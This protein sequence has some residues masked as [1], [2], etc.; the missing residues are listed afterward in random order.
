MR[1]RIGKRLTAGDRS[2]ARATWEAV[3]AELDRWSARWLDARVATCEAAKPH[4]DQPV[5]LMQLRLACLDEQL[6]SLAAITTLLASEPA[7]LPDADRQLERALAATLELPDPA[8]CDHVSLLGGDLLHD[9]TGDDEDVQ[10]GREQLNHARALLSMAKPDEALAIVDAVLADADAGNLGDDGRGTLRAEAELLRGR[11]F[12]AAGQRPRAREQLRDALMLAQQLGHD[13]MLIEAGA[14]LI[15]VLVADGELE[16]AQ[17][18]AELA[19]A[20]VIRLGGDAQ[21]EAELHLA[22]AGLARARGQLADAREELDLVLALREQ[23]YGQQHVELAEPLLLRAD[24]L[25]Q[26]HRTREAE[27]DV[28]RALDLLNSAYG[29][30]H[31]EVGRAYVRAAAVASARGDRAEALAKLLDA[32]AIFELA[33]GPTHARVLEVDAMIAAQR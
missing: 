23:A 11:I 32:R 14:A 18:W 5:A 26:L 30:T 12:V 7:N 24:V 3:G 25:A 29:I 2:Y 20:T 33:H 13:A 1:E 16:R 9:D 15:D 6:G 19:R 27:A 21:L 8:R 22:T 17:D 28:E 10:H 4:G 31:P